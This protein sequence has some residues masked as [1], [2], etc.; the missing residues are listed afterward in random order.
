MIFLKRMAMGLTALLFIAGLIWLDVYLP[1]ARTVTITGTE[2]K[3][4]DEDGPISAENPEDG[5]TRDVYFIFGNTDEGDTLVVR[6]EDTGWS[7][8][9][10]FK[11]DSADMQAVA[12]KAGADNQRMAVTTYG[13]R[14]KMLSWFPNAIS[15]KPISTDEY[16]HSWAR[17]I[18]FGLYLM[19]WGYLIVRFARKRKASVGQA[20]AVGDARHDG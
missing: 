18:G 5:P 20:L 10:Y 14:V 12:Q 16:G 8:P 9:P 11:F 17:I 1:Y 3:R 19:A 13:W 2:V 15:L 7:W 6:N 4:M